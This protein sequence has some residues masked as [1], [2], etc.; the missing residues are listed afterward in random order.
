MKIN[1]IRCGAEIETIH[2]HD[3]NSKPEQEMW[4]GGVVDVIA[5]NYGSKH[6]GEMYLIA[7]CDNCIDNCLLSGKIKWRG[8]YLA[9]CVGFFLK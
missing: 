9:G 8:N 7:V 1:C 6:D 2:E 5:A 4:G 3:D